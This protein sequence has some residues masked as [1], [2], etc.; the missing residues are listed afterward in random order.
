MSEKPSVPAPAPLRP[1][2]TLGQYRLVKHLGRG[3]TGLVFEALHT[4]LQRPVALKTLR[5]EF[6]S[7]PEVR[8]RFLREGIAAS[9]IRHRAVADVFD[10]GEQDGTVYLVMELLE[11]ESLAELLRREAPLDPTRAA[12]LLVPVAAAL[13]TAHAVGVIHRDVKPANIYVAFTRQGIEPKVLDFGISK[14]VTQEG[15]DRTP[16]NVT[17]DDALLG[18]PR[19]MAPEQVRGARL[20]TAA[21]DQY[22]L[23]VVLYEAL[24]GETPFDGR[25]SYEVMSAIMKTRLRPPSA[26]RPGLPPALE[27]VVLRAMRR[28]PGARF[29]SLTAFGAA[30][31][32]FASEAVRAQWSGAFPEPLPARPL[33]E[34]ARPAGRVAILAGAALFSVVLGLGVGAWVKHRRGLRVVATPSV[35]A[36]HRPADQP[37]LT[38]PRTEEAAPPMAAAGSPAMVSGGDAGGAPEERPRRRRAAR[39][40][41]ERTPLGGV[42]IP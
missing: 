26:L 40:R 18:T 20:V 25:N 41:V 39:E 1:G 21:S 33:E 34:P 19:Y 3:G 8:A 24:T 11:G 10:V 12:D 27:A 35:T 6:A 36:I 5:P 38:A 13:A 31:L 29:T 7:V 9:R 2:A 16:S 23:G 37:L 28:S 4:G 15:E 30:L 22:S 17:A 42:I 32:P 14:V